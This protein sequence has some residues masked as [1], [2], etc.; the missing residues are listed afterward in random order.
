MAQAQPQA[1]PLIEFTEA[2]QVVLGSILIRREIPASTTDLKPEHFY[3]GAHGRIFQ[4]GPDFADR[5]DRG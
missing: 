3:R 1:I 5:A 4:P 2:E